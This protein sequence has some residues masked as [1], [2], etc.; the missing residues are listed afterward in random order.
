MIIRDNYL[1]KIRPYYNERV[2]KIINGVR[3]CGKTTLIEQIID[4]LINNGVSNDHIY[5]IDFDKYENS[6][7]TNSSKITKYL[8]SI[9]KDNKMYY[10]FFDEVQNLNDWSKLLGF[11]NSIKKISIFVTSSSY[12]LN[13]E[14]S[15]INDYVWFTMYPISY[16]E[17]CSI[18]E[19]DSKKYL[20]EYLKW[21]GMPYQLSNNNN[22]FK[23]T[24][25]VNVYNTLIV[26]DI[27]TRFN[28]KDVELL[29]RIINY[30]LDNIPNQLSVKNMSKLFASYDRKVSLDTLYNYLE[31]IESS[32]L[33]CKLE[34][35]DMKEK[36][37]ISGKAKYYLSDLSMYNLIDKEID[38]KYKLEN[39][40]YLELI[41]RGYDVKQ[42]IVGLKEIDFIATKGKEKKYIEVCEYITEDIFKKYNRITDDVEKYIFS[43]DENNFSSKKVKHLNIIKFLLNKNF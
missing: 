6:I 8:D 14:L 32:F 1:E 31:C 21:G 3:R 39:L 41:S 24:A 37:I 27:I 30:I 29:D 26:K 36:R 23:K 15:L 12:D 35:Y 28:L 13:N 34:R 19:V 7:Y 4:E 5:I 18:K 16:K 40:I 33:L 43:L 2:I 38:T 25:M 10:L 11:Y 17:L 20:S 22:S 42:A 9:I